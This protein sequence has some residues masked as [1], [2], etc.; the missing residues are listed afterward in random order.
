ML[1]EQS[2]SI[3]KMKIGQIPGIRSV[4]RRGFSGGPLSEA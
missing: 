2:A 1:D 3:V 4:Q